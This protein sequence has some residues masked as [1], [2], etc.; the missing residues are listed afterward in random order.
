MG[1]AWSSHEEAA[2]DSSPEEVWNAIASG[3]GVDSW[4]M[5]R[6]VVDPEKG[7]DFDTSVQGFTLHSTIE[8]WEPPKRLAYRTEETADGRFVANE[9]LV[10]GR[11]ASTTI[12]RLV[13]SGFLPGDEWEDEYEA[14]RRGGELYFHTLVTYL[15]RFAGHYAR[16]VGAYGPPITDW[17]GAWARLGTA[18]GL[19]ASPAVGQRA[20]FTLTGNRPID[21]T[22]DFVNPDAIGLVSNDALYRFTKGFHTRGFFVSHHIF[23]E[24]DEDQEARAWTTWLADLSR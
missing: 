21:A 10:E 16:P 18:I 11:G 23:A 19:P 4:F 1:R 2:L 7:G 8:T 5:G 3:P 14:M 6:T 22:V 20:R 12:L 24:V 17:D 15:K 9:Y 13:V